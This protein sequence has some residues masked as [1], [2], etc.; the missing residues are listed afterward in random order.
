MSQFFQKV[1]YNT[2]RQEFLVRNNY[3]LDAAE[4]T[5]GENLLFRKLKDVM[6]SFRSDVD[7]N[8]QTQVSQQSNS[9]LQKKLSQT[10]NEFKRSH[11]QLPSYK[12]I[13]AIEKSPGSP[14]DKI[15][16]SQSL[17]QFYYK[18]NNLKKRIGQQMSLVE[19]SNTFSTKY[20]FHSE[21]FGQGLQVTSKQVKLI[22]DCDKSIAFI[23]PSIYGSGLAREQRVTLVI[24]VCRNSN[25]RYPMAV[26]ICD[27]QK[28]QENNFVFTGS[29]EHMPGSNNK[30]HGCYLLNSNGYI[31]SMTGSDMIRSSPNL[32][33]YSNSTLE[34]TFK[35]FH[36]QLIINRD[37]Q[38]QTTIPLE[39]YKDQKLFFCVR[40]ADLHDCIEI[41]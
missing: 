38:V 31:R 3:I 34:L 22:L 25:Q 1:E 29:A 14:D 8:Y 11:Q 24:K 39:F 17:S 6:N 10:N 21:C 35:P 12:K 7:M 19:T 4:E 23:K 33:F 20:S 13:T 5:D 32:R 2:K 41:L 16:V 40:L 18:P 28:L 30:D 27:Q 37:Q 26:G 9:H 15:S 36:K